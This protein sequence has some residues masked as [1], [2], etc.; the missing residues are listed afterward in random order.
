MT[1]GAVVVG[2]LGVDGAVRAV[3]VVGVGVDGAVGAVAV[4]G[5]GVKLTLGLFCSYC[6]ANVKLSPHVQ[7]RVRKQVEPKCK[8]FK[9]EHS[10]Y[11]GSQL[12]HSYVGE[13][14]YL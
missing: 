1:I 8:M 12:E 10:S 4:G 13:T 7:C 6:R 11:I 5:V 9:L 3:V 14:L 2:G